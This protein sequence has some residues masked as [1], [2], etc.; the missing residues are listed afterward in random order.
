MSPPPLNDDFLQQPHSYP[1]HCIASFNL[2]NRMR[3]NI[4]LC[5]VKLQA[6]GEII[7]AHKVI[8]ASASPYFYAMFNGNY[9]L[10]TDQLPIGRF[11]SL[12]L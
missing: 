2:I 5:D 1:G 4:Q 8:L 3:Q 7:H 10:S 6:G 12:S 9:C 11:F